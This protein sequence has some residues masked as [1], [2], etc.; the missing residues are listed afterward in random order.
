MNV[1]PLLPSLANPPSRLEITL[2]WI[3]SALLFAAVVSHFES[4]LTEV[5]KVGDNVAYMDAAYAIRAWSFQ[6]VTVKQF[7]GLPYAIVLLSFVPTVTLKAALLLVSL[8]C[9]LLGVLLI[10]RLW[11]GWIAVYFALLNFDWMQRSYLGGAEPLFAALLFASFFLV[12]RERWVFATVLGALATLVR[13]VGMLELVA[14]ALVLLSKREYRKV[15]ACTTVGAIIGVLY[16]IPFW[17]Y[18][19]DPLY[20][21]HRYQTSDWNSGSAVGL[22]FHALASSLLHTPGPITNFALTSGWIILVIVGFLAMFRKGFRATINARSAEFIFAFLYLGFLLTYN[23]GWAR[24]EFPRFAI[25]LLPFVLAALEPWL[26]KSRSGL[27]AVGAV[28]SI[29]AACSAI[30]IR[31]VLA[32]LH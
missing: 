9:S 15:I 18:F 26:P 29:L 24:A 2:L 7:W 13:P 27:Y 6:N 23:S 10:E 1:K 28:S 19:H 21:V 12:R 3:L 25:P 17:I 11:G 32:A 4:Y 30:G 22:P 31:N 16:L 20:Q 8:S 14:I 5:D